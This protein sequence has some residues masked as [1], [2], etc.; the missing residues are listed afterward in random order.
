M[1]NRAEYLRVMPF[2]HVLCLFLKTLEGNKMLKQQVSDEEIKKFTDDVIAW[3]KD[4]HE[5][6]GLIR[7]LEKHKVKKF[8][9]IQALFYHYKKNDWQWWLNNQIIQFSKLHNDNL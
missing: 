7:Y 5:F 6:E 4:R 8:E 3:M 2:A 1:I 9:F